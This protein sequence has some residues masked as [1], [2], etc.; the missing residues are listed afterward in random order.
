MSARYEVTGYTNVKQAG[1][2]MSRTVK[3]SETAKT[4][5]EANTLFDIMTEDETIVL[6]V[7]IVD[8]ASGK[9]VRTTNN[10]SQ[11]PI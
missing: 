8:L 3:V 7:A 10:P 5:A 4:A 2:Y 6:E 9:V 1:S 11:Q